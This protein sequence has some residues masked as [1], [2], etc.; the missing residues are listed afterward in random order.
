MAVTLGTL[1]I[2]L[3][4]DA[5]DGVPIRAQRR[6]AVA[7]EAGWNG[8]AGLGANFTYNVLPRLSLDLGLGLSAVGLKSGARV[9]A[10]LLRSSWT[11]IVGLGFLYGWGAGDE[12]I[13]YTSKGDTA[14]FHV[15]SSPYL[16]AVAGVNYTGGGGLTFMA[17]AGYAFLLRKE[18]LEF[19]SGSTAAY[20]DARDL[21]G[22]GVVLGAS[23]GYAF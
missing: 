13:K 21:C 23:L 5:A 2:S 8:L 10:N 20:D 14:R 11:P 17:T 15:R 4:A 19:I 16:Q 3:K 18:N 12:E 7:G 1:L 6:W 9:R 22:S